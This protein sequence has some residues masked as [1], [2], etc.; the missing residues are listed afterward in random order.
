MTVYA[1][2]YD[3]VADRCMAVVEA[4]VNVLV[5]HVPVPTVC[6]GCGA[7]RSHLTHAEAGRMFSRAKVRHSCGG[8]LR[9]ATLDRVGGGR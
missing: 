9:M 8:L 6:A 7:E 4:A 3:A 5:L 2:R 1:S